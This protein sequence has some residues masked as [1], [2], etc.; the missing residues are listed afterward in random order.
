MNSEGR[1]RVALI[2]GGKG[3]ECEVSLRGKEHILPLIDKEKYEV[4][5]LFIDK[6]GVWRIGD[7]PALPYGG[8]FLC[9]ESGRKIKVDCAFP[10][11]HGDFG[12]DGRVQ[13]ALECAAIPY[14]GCSVW[15]AAV[16][17]DKALVKTVATELGIPTLPSITLL[18]S[19]GVDYAVRQTEARLSYPL[20]VKPTCLGSSVG[21]GMAENTDALRSALTDAFALSERVMAEPY[22]E[23]KRELECGYFS[24]KGKELFTNPGEILHEGTY[25]Y[26]DKYLRGKAGL[27]IRAQVDEWVKE[28]V[29]EYSRRLVRMLSVRDLS[30]IDFFLSGD[31]LYFNEINTMPGFTE[32]SLYA[33]MVTAHGMSEGRLIESLIDNATGRG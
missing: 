2:Y 17:R 25:G 22:L 3:H 23:G 26:E 1:T 29:R 14:V 16:C 13:G 9:P 7:E 30:R 18:R 8:G 31:R 19:E 4:I 12:E 5:P 6:S 15:S 27:A 10:L 28:A 21:V 32:G 24:T 20:F 11:L 33:K